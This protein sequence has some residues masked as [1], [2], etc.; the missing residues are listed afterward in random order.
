M[1]RT[2]A[3][4][5]VTVKTTDNYVAILGRIENSISGIIILMLGIVVVD[6]VRAAIGQLA[7]Y[8]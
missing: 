7:A 8:M 4:N 6:M 1:L 5:I 2:V 3:L